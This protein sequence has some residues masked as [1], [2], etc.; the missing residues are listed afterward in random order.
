MYTS[1]AITS[2]VR[3]ARPMIQEIRVKSYAALVLAIGPL[4]ATSACRTV[5]MG[6]TPAGGSSSG[7]SSMVGAAT[8]KGAVEM[9]LTAAKMQDIQALS[10]VWGDEKGMT[11]DRVDRNELETRSIDLICLLKHDSERIGE[12]QQASG[13]RFLINTDLTQGT[14]RATTTFTVARSPAGRWLVTTFDVVAL[15]SKGFCRRTGG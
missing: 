3:P 8:P 13:N 7:L 15:Q 11:R 6:V 5:Q 14:N 9:M 10:A 2:T 1:P 12:P 4:A